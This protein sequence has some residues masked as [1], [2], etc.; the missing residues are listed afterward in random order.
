MSHVATSPEP[1]LLFSCGWSFWLGLNLS[2]DGTL[3]K[4][5]DGNLKLLKLLLATAPWLIPSV[6]PCGVPDCPPLA[7]PRESANWTNQR[8]KW[9]INTVVPTSSPQF[10]DHVQKWNNAE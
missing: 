4:D 5:N 1:L 10:D 7:R 9:F 3:L 2:T 8:V 6:V